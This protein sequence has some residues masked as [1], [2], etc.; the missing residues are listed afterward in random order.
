MWRTLNRKQAMFSYCMTLDYKCH[1]F[2]L[3]NT[4]GIMD[5]IHSRYFRIGI[6]MMVI[7]LIYWFWFSKM[8]ISKIGM[9]DVEDFPMLSQIKSRI[10]DIRKEALNIKRPQ[11][12]WV[13]DREVFEKYLKDVV[14][15]NDH[16]IV[17]WGKDH[18]WLN[19]PLVYNDIIIQGKTERLC[20]ITTTVLS[21]IKGIKVAGFSRLTANGS[22][23]KHKDQN[24]DKNLLTYH[25]CLTGNCKLHVGKNVIDQ[26]PGKD[27]IFDSNVE[28]SVSNDAKND[29]IILH[30]L[31][32]KSVHH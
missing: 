29:R 18:E 11:N 2:L 8:S 20:P 13:H 23:A 19:Y 28:H 16:W 1:F 17:S 25:L 22:I 32:D 6:C 30:I 24:G 9:Y 15:E 4:K 7:V 5:M 3:K 21:G 12:V 10:D 31:F 26:I 14:K 27:L